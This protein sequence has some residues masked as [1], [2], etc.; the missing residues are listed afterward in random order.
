MKLEAEK[1]NK[2]IGRKCITLTGARTDVYNV[3]ATSKLVIGVSRVAL[4]AMAEKKPVILAGNP[5]YAQGYMGI[6]TAD[7]LQMARENNFCCRGYAVSDEEMLSKDVVH[8]LKHLTQEERD[9][10][11]AYGREIIHQYYSVTRMAEDCVVA[12]DAATEESKAPQYRR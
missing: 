4:E 5:S 6:F 10:I 3:I 11:G 8:V 7:K 1:A 12:Y 2:K 9:Q